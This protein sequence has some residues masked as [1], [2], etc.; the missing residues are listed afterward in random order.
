MNRCLAIACGLL[1]GLATSALPAAASSCVPG[2]LQ[3]YLGAGPCMIGGATFDDFSLL[4]LAFG[5]SPID[6]SL[7]QVTP[8]SAANQVGFRFGVIASTTDVFETFF[9][10]SVAGAGLTRATLQMAGS[11]ASGD[12]VVTAVQ[13]VCVGGSFPGG[14]PV[15]CPGAAVS[16]IVFEIEGDNDLDESS[17]FAAATF[18]DVDND[19]F[20]DGGLAGSA[21]LAGSITNLFDIQAQ[22]TAV[23]EPATGLLLVTGLGAIVRRR[24]QRRA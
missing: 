18:L 23:P 1:V 12:G 19:L 14:L 7:I 21:A 4:P 22:P 5:S 8:L 17:S 10:Y 2:T 11:V 3:T 24:L 16:N 15:G 13:D 9:H 6:A 20:I